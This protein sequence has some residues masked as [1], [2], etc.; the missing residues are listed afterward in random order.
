MASVFALAALT[1]CA[2]QQ[3][4]QA[5]ALA[6]RSF[7]EVSSCPPERTVVV[8]RSDLSYEDKEFFEVTGCGERRIIRCSSFTIG[9]TRTTGCNWERPRSSPPLF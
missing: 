4:Q 6:R 3:H 5:M 7:G 9:S 2:P 1:S 8:F